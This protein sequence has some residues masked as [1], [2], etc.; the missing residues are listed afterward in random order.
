MAT[1]PQESSIMRI[2]SQRMK[3]IEEKANNQ[4][5]KVFL[6]A[7][8]YAKQGFYVIPIRKNGKFLPPKDY[9]VNYGSA[10]KNPQVVEG[11][12]HPMEGK[13]AGWNIGIATGREGGVF[14]VDV[15]RHGSDDGVNNWNEIVSS[16]EIET[17]PWQTTPN[18]GMH[19]LYQW[20]EN[21]ISSTGKI[22]PGIDT[23]GGTEAA[24]KGHIVVWPS[25]IDGKE[26]QWAEG[27]EIPPI[28]KYVIEKMGLA[29]KPKGPGRGNESMST[30]DEE[31]Q[32]PV[33]QLK[34]MLS[35]IDPED[36]TY[37]EWLRVGQAINS[38]YPGKD[39][40]E[41]W[42]DWSA[43]GS[44]YE[45][46]EC[47]IR[48][49]G[50][51]PSGP[52]RVGSLFFY[53]KEAGWE[54][55]KGDVKK[56]NPIDEVVE[57]INKQ[58]AIVVVGGK[59]RVLREKS[60][61]EDPVLGNY[62]LLGVNDFQSL[63]QNEVVFIEDNNGNQKPV[64][65]ARIWLAHEG[66]RTY[67]NGMGLFPDDN[68]PPGFYNTWTGFAFQ[69]IKGNC[70]LLLNHI[71]EVICNDSERDYEWLL[72]WCADA[73]Q[74]PSDPKGT[75]VVMRGEEGAGKGTLANTMG[76][77]FGPH[78]RHLIDDS[79]LLSNFN[80][81][82]IDALFVFAD[83][84]TWGG[85]KKTAGKLKGMVTEKYLV[86]E[87]KGVDAV[88]YRNMSRIM[89]ASNGEWVVPAGV[90]SRRWFILDVNASKTKNRQHFDDLN[91][92][93][94]GGGI[95]AFLYFLL[96]RKI[97]SDLRV[98]PVTA[99]L[100]EQRVRTSI[101]DSILQWWIRSV[102]NEKLA[103]AEAEINDPSQITD[104]P[105]VVLKQ[106][107]YEEYERWAMERHINPEQ[108]AVFYS[109][110]YDFGL[111]RGRKTIRG[112][113]KQVYVVPKHKK[114]VEILAEKFNIDV[115]EDD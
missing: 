113:K 39:G 48:W 13:F 33:D 72:D 94:S 51:D 40:L 22:A 25:V 43:K 54:P 63:L 32:I 99:A 76:R 80:A 27:G 71:R 5:W 23:R 36:V 52:V 114:A 90:N 78:Y 4:E 42:D 97:T 30:D 45:K 105:E 55:Q 35:K 104:W 100:K 11:W 93:L 3:E 34:R 26:Y 91:K 58:H 60:Y 77:M 89:I 31:Q 101:S 24:C 28:P 47:H 50:F 82:M 87:R 69:P 21:A 14:A 70:S 81:H 67:P 7:M 98:A 6:A 18:G 83:E 108:I 103:V 56:S 38:Q 9:H 2:S 79:H 85:N 65:V 12:F 106:D 95:N 10:S 20:T 19:Y 84:I 57:K 49:E 62:E 46:G 64:Q 107:I 86:G 75:A 73:V 88:G 61:V 37:D 1:Q 109:R 29:W 110:M 74:N 44:R 15:D 102:M 59:V 112:V 96:N 115:N 53:A 8:E 17:G 111:E 41:I 16:N 66:R 68:A 92:E